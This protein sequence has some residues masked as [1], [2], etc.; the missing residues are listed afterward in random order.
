M[1]S[2]KWTLH[3][4]IGRG[5]NRCTTT[6]GTRPTRRRPRSTGAPWRS[7]PVVR[8]ATLVVFVVSACSAEG[9][10]DGIEQPEADGERG[11]YLVELPALRACLDDIDPEDSYLEIA[12]DYFAPSAGLLEMGAY[13][14]SFDETRAALLAFSNE[15]STALAAVNPELSFATFVGL[16]AGG[17]QMSFAVS[18]LGPAASRDDP[19]AALR[20]ASDGSAGVWSEC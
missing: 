8:L 15:L 20:F 14:V 1:T 19:L 4:V 11:S 13:V 9:T 12:P 17:G 7:H 2:S 6:V 16:G 18:V 5:D 3:A 10:A